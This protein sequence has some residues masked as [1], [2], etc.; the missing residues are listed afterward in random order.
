MSN[1]APKIAKR[2]GREIHFSAGAVI[3][4]GDKLLLIDRVKPPFGLAGPAGH[5]DEGEDPEAAI[6]REVQEET[7]LTVTGAKL[8]FDEFVDWNECSKGVTGHHWYVY[9][10]QTKGDIKL[11]DAEASGFDWYGAEDLRDIELEPVW[12]YWFEKMELL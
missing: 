1:P 11:A 2:Q 9:E 12:E 8:L 6:R 5:V 10:C 3:R 7:G 4:R